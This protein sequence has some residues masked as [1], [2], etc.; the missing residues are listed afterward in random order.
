MAR[1]NMNFRA[2]AGLDTSNFKRGVAEIRGSIHNLGSEFKNFGAMMLGGFGLASFV[3]KIKD[4]VKEISTA[5]ATLRNVSSSMLEFNQSSEWLNRLSKDWAQNINVLTQNFA[6][7]QASCKNTNLSLGQQRKIFEAITK[8]STY[9]HLSADQTNNVM[10][11]INQMMSKGK[12]AAEE[13][14]RQLGNAMPGAFNIMAKAVGVS[15]AQ[16]EDM[17]RK[18]Q[19][20]SQDV[21]P[22]FAK[23]LEVM[24]QNADLNSIQLQLNNLSNAWVDF[25][26]AGNFEGIYSSGIKGLTG[27]LQGLIAPMKA[28]SGNFNT[29]KFAIIEMVGSYVLLN[30]IALPFWRYSLQK[31]NEYTNALKSQTAAEMAKKRQLEAA[32]ATQM[33]MFTQE[34]AQANNLAK[35]NSK[36]ATQQQVLEKKKQE[37]QKATLA[38]QKATAEQQQE[39][40]AKEIAAKNAVIK[41]E[42]KL[43]ALEA[44]RALLTTPKKAAYVSPTV[45][46][47]TVNPEV[48]KTLKDIEATERRI[49][50]T[51]NTI[52]AGTTKWGTLLKGVKG[53]FATISSFL[54]ANLLLAAIN[55]IFIGISKIVDKIKEG[56]KEAK[57]FGDLLNGIQSRLKDADS[58]APTVE[59]D[60]LK[61]SL[62]VLKDGTSTLKE[63]LNA[64]NY[65]NET[66]GRTTKDAFSVE[67][68][69]NKW[70]E[71]ENAVDGYIKKVLDAG[72]ESK[73]LAEL[74]T[75]KN[76]RKLRSE[77]MRGIEN[78]YKRTNI[79]FS[80]LFSAENQR[81]RNYQAPKGMDKDDYNRYARLTKEIAQ[82]DSQYNSVLERINHLY[83]KAG[84][85]LVSEAK[86]VFTSL[87]STSPKANL[88]AFLNEYKN[89]YQKNLKNPNIQGIK[90]EYETVQ[91]WLKNWNENNGAG[92]NVEKEKIQNKTFEEWV[93][94]YETEVNKLNSSFKNGG[95]TQ[96]KYIEKIGKLSEK[97]YQII[98]SFT[99]FDKKL[100]ESKDN[101]KLQVAA[102]KKAFDLSEII[103]ETTK[104]RKEAV[105]EQKR[106]NRELISNAKPSISA[107]VKADKLEEQAFVGRD[108]TF[109]YRLDDAGQ[110]T[111]DY[112]FAEKTA[113]EYK[114]VIEKLRE[115][116]TEG[117]EK[118]ES[119]LEEMLSK[120]QSLK[121]IAFVAEWKKDIKELNEQMSKGTVQA[122]NQV[123]SGVQGLYN[124]IKGVAESIREGGDA[125]E[126]IFGVINSIVQVLNTLVN[127]TETFNNLS[128]IGEQLTKAEG[129]A[130]LQKLAAKQSSAL[131][132]QTANAKESADKAKN[133]ALTEAQAVAE[134]GLGA[135][136]VSS[137]VAATSAT[138]ASL[139][140][141]QAAAAVQQKKA[142]AGAA[143]SGAKL[144]F[145]ANLVAIAA[146]VS[147]VVGALSMIGKFAN[148]GIV[149]GSSTSGDRVLA[150]L[151]SGEMVLN[152]KQQGTLF[153]L[154]DGKGNLGSTGEV[155][156]KI[157]GPNLVG[158]LN[159]YSKQRKG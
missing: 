113:E 12:V 153:N 105:N 2:S 87:S 144:P 51:Q 9:F 155:N 66:L 58:N 61:S 148:G 31:T 52:N 35:I 16:L 54:K 67:D 104:A 75:I 82:L 130:E 59:A 63:R 30:K 6:Q 92:G 62:K 49:A 56:N 120:A 86:D 122:I 156:F 123:S 70:K 33:S 103:G 111:A 112:E 143:A 79:N 34:A 96:E 139:P 78:K 99:D 101:V 7:F 147:A 127:L 28:I 4:T 106:I 140:V 88:K 159:N 121:E 146:G 11:A 72:K 133:I 84:G 91:D 81:A 37:L 158:V 21:L 18:G 134:T 85:D 42:Q 117:L 13:L 3:G 132:S 43:Q 83:K 68:V 114:Q 76:E 126:V 44:K 93:R 136:K 39:L 102:I 10:L 41:A 46:V 131:A 64:L 149:G 65:I 36:I 95:I 45:T 154:L 129:A 48:E 57:E 145:P 116:G 71:L 137:E 109:D 19:L 94:Y 47:G 26:K 157:S 124:S 115:L 29:M 110:K 53:V 150:R 141:E 15:T 55:L 8:A 89:E 1:N 98:T 17:M 108:K 14:R 142:I 152:K 128:K 27:L 118:M 74:T 50:S 32:L 135:A 22:K 23:E 69:K 151:N 119:D 5:E 125:F 24:T 73:Y 138:A 100:S 97:V 38:L 40:A 77:E 20:L 107:F 90:I 25:V 80:T 60:R